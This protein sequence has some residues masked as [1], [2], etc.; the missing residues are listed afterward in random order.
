MLSDDADEDLLF[1]LRIHAFPLYHGDRVSEIGHDPSSDV[2]RMIGDDLDADGAISTE[3][4]VVAEL[5][6]R[7]G[8]ENTADDRLK[9]KSVDKIGEQ[10]DDGIEGE[11][12]AHEV[13]VGTIMMDNGGDDIRTAGR[14][15]VLHDIRR[16]DPGKGACGD[17]C[18]DGTRPVV[19]DIAERGQVENA[20]VQKDEHE[21]ECD[22][23]DEGTDGIRAPYDEKSSD[24]ERDIDDDGD[25]SDAD[26]E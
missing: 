12:D 7:E 2:L 9:L 23:H 1:G 19:C 20:F 18:Q 4:K 13:I 14:A 22:A 3:E 10:S 8:I 26:T 21:G 15:A 16:D 24:A 6:G 11:D 17:G 25:I 5:T